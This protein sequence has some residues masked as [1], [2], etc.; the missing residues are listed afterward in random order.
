MSTI[1]VDELITELVQEIKI[2]RPTSLAAFRPWVYSHNN[3]EGNFSFIIEKDSLPVKIFSFTNND[4]KTALNV[5][6][7]YFHG[8]Y[9]I[10]VTPF[11]LHRGTYTIKLTAS[12]YTYNPNC[13]VGWCKDVEAF[14]K[15]YGTIENYTSNPYSFT[16]VEYRAREL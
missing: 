6:Q 9:A 1:V 15:T 13:F 5:T 7:P 14:G 3:P 8:R 2:N 10:P 16:L 12:G 11:I 4:L